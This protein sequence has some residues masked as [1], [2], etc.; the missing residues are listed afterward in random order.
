MGSLERARAAGLAHLRVGEC[1]AHFGRPPVAPDPP[2]APRTP[3]EQK[4][5]Y[6][7][8][9]KH[10]RREHYELALGRAVSDSELEKL[11]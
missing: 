6:E 8:S 3:D 10:A 2:P 11:P 9:A 1:E 4:A 7:A 5:D